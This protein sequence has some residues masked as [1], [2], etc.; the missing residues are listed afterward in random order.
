[1]HRGDNLPDLSFPTDMKNV[2]LFT[3]HVDASRDIH[4]EFLLSIRPS[5]SGL[6]V[7]SVEFHVLKIIK[8]ISSWTM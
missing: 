2:P 4:S 6:G 8:L 1:M 5:R 3:D 7:F